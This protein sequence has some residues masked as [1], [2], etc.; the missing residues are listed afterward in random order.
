M[1]DAIPNFFSER[2]ESDDIRALVSNNN[3]LVFNSDQFSENDW[4]KAYDNVKPGDKYTPLLK[5]TS[6]AEAAS[7]YGTIYYKP[8]GVFQ[9][10][11]CYSACDF[12]SANIQ[13][14]DIGTIFGEDLQSG[15]GGC[16]D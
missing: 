10:A 15:G 11:V 12:F 1:A 6:S 4:G 16:F 3:K 9:N 5:L 13:D 14:N 2:F 7:L 8:I